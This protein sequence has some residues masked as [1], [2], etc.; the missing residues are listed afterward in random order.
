ML[1]SLPS[2]RTLARSQRCHNLNHAKH[3]YAARTF[4]QLNTAKG[5][6]LDCAPMEAA[7][8]LERHCTVL[9]IFL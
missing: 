5:L 6:R 1:L 3:E 7:N 4:D 2:C 9:G 8:V